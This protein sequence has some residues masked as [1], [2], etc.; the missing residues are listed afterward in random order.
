MY[1]FGR[2]QYGKES[3]CM[4]LKESLVELT[5]LFQNGCILGWHFVPSY[6]SMKHRR[7]DIFQTDLRLFYFLELTLLMAFC[8]LTCQFEDVFDV[9]GT[10]TGFLQH[11]M[12]RPT[13]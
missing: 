12:T 6:S 4:P 10:H 1:L 13:N 3:D 5:L 11:K 9:I 7:L 8:G 2:V